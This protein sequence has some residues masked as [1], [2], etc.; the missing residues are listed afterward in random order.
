MRCDLLLETGNLLFLLART[1]LNI[2]R[3]CWISTTTI[4]RR[5][6]K[7]RIHAEVITLTNRV[8]LMVVAT[9]TIKSQPHPHGAHRFCLIKNIFH[10]VLRRDTATFAVDHVVT[11]EA[12]RQ[13]LLLRC[14][15]QQITGDLFHGKVVVRLIGIEG[16]NHPVTPW[17]HSTFTVTLIPIAIG[18]PC[19][20]EP[21]PSHTL[22]ISRRS[23]KA[24]GYCF[25]CLMRFVFLES[26]HFSQS[27]G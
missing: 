25:K 17:P 5:L 20:L 7:E 12:R 1:H 21:I 6:I 15:R 24:V 3:H 11:I 26:I 18:I 13:H 22:T 2:G 19:G 14:I 16:A 27:G 8:K 9:A 10:A 23:Q 4:H